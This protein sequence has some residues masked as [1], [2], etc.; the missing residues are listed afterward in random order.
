VLYGEFLRA[1]NNNVSFNT[2]GITAPVCDP[3]APVGTEACGAKSN[4]K[5]WGLGV[6]QEIDAA[7]MS[8][9]VKY[10]HLSEDDNVGGFST[11]DF[12]YVGTGAL[13]NF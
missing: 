11:E 2:A 10:R 7:A 12:D 4:V 5:V 3:L 9:W 8:V 6:V 1:E 13:I